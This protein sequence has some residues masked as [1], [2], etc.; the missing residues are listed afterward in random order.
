[1]LFFCVRPYTVK[2]QA[3]NNFTDE[4]DQLF[5]MGIQILQQSKSQK[6]KAE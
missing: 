6:Q 5:N 1:M 2:K 4:G 3:K